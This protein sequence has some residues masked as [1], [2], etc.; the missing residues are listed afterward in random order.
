MARSLFRIAALGLAALPGAA[1]AQSTPVSELWR[2]WAVLEADWQ[3]ERAVYD[4]DRQRNEAL[5]NG[6]TPPPTT[7]PPASPER[8]AEG[9]RR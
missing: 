8:P 4:R 7:P 9:E 5:R 1:R 3:A 2:E 6:Q